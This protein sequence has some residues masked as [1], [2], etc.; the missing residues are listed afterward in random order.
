MLWVWAC[1]TH[2]ARLLWWLHIQWTLGAWHT[3]W[4]VGRASV[5]E[6]G[7]Y[8]LGWSK[9]L[10]SADSRHV[11]L[12]AQCYQNFHPFPRNLHFV[13]A[14]L[15]HFQ[16]LT[17]F[18]KHTHIHTHR[19]TGGIHGQFSTLLSGKSLYVSMLSHAHC[20]LGWGGYSVPGAPGE[21]TGRYTLQPLP[22]SREG[23]WRQV[24]ESWVEEGHLCRVWAK[25][26]DKEMTDFCELIRS[27]FEDRLNEK[28]K[29][30]TCEILPAI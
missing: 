29:V 19:P 27:H 20:R 17:N 24:T 14:K 30:W 11:R 23:G 21:H 8:R 5:P 13:N 26:E 16:F 4:K 7:H 6:Q 18:W 3:A 22:S 25:G 10:P 15:P 1:A 9:G 2:L 12:E 28:S